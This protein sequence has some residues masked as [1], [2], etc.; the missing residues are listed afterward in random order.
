MFKLDLYYTCM[1]I[2]IFIKFGVDLMKNRSY[3][4]RE[5]YDFNLTKILTD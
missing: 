5:F 1:L 3:F 4:D 2:N